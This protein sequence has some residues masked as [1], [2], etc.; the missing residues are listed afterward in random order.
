MIFLKEIN[1]YLTQ[2]QITDI[3]CYL[4]YNSF[5]IMYLYTVKPGY[6][7]TG[8]GENLV[9]VNNFKS[10]SLYRLM[11]NYLTS[12]K[13]HLGKG[14]FRSLA[15]HPNQVLLYMKVFFFIHN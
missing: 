13:P 11:L 6:G 14:F 5:T 15:I 1:I 9:W 3:N 2:P 12:V 8:Y 10:P 4:T 7:S